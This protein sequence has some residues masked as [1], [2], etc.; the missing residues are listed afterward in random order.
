[1]SDFTISLYQNFSGTA[2]DTSGLTFEVE[3]YSHS[4]IGGPSAAEI[5]VTGDKLLLWKL[6]NRLGDELKIHCSKTGDY[7]WWGY[8]HEIEVEVDNYRAYA[9]MDSLANRIRVIYPYMDI[10]GSVLTG[11]TGNRQESDWIFDGDSIEAF[12]LKEMTYST[13]GQNAEY[14]KRLQQSLLN[15]YRKPKVVITQIRSTKKTASAT[16]KCRGWWETLDWRYLPRKFIT[17]AYRD[18]G[19]GALEFGYTGVCAKVAQS[20]IPATT[21]IPKVLNVGMRKTGAPTDNITAAIYSDSGGT[22]SASLV[23]YP[24]Y[25]G[26]SLLATD[27]TWPVFKYSGT[28]SL[29]GGTTYWIILDRDGSDSITDY[30]VADLTFGGAYVNGQ[31]KYL[32]GTAWTTASVPAADM[33]FSIT[34]EV[35][36]AN[37]DTATQ[38]HDIIEDYGAIVPLSTAVILD[39]S[40]ISTSPYRERENTALYEIEELIELGTTN[41]RRLLMKVRKDRVMEIY[42]EPAGTVSGYFNNNGDI[43]NSGG[44]LLMKETCPCGIYL[45]LAGVIPDGILGRH[46]SPDKTMFI[47]KSEYIPKTKELRIASAEMV[48][49]FDFLVVRNE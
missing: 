15:K 34:G 9:S 38:I 16:L 11:Y 21:I 26:T 24:N 6:L 20:F 43:Y 5:T 35:I 42:E 14:A 40:G 32:A 37:T 22:P 12:G 19:S 8:V 47:E 17:V 25:A 33:P 3:R 2:I 36:D 28:V 45:D 31:M 39:A 48:S 13:N 27:F 7:V 30:Y 23:S 18:F 41:N 29:T 10:A 4:A 49:E 44:G 1:M 46:L